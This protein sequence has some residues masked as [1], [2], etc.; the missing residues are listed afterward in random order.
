MR[1][2]IFVLGTRA[3][4]V[5]ISPVLRIAAET[6]L[7]HTVWFT[8]QHHESIDDLID[9]FGLTSNIIQPQD[10]KERSS[11]GKLLLWIPS[12]VFR[13]F[14]FVRSARQLPNGRPLVVVHGDTLSTWLGAI[15]GK[16]A[17][18][19]IVHLESGLSSGKWSD[20]F[21]EELLRR[22][23]FRISSY[24]LC[25]NDEATERMAAYPKCVVINTHENTLL[26]CV[27]YALKNRISGSDL[28]AR[29]VVSIHRFQ[30]LYQKARLDRIVGEIRQLAE[31][32]LVAFILHPPTELRLRKYGLLDG[33]RNTD[34][35]NLLPRMPYTEFLALMG[36]ADM[37][38][39]DG[40]SNQE[41]LSYLGVPTVLYRDRSERPD[42]LGGNIIFRRELATTLTDAV[43]A[44]DIEKLRRE[45]RINDDIHPS[46][47][48]VDAL[49]A[50]ST[51]V[52]DSSSND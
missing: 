35:V 51:A 12:T 33:L 36:D 48:T 46:K 2:C 23:T 32:G 3:Q 16:F 43:V 52:V 47:L 9:D 5:K 4:L 39:S 7:N 8:G 42:G 10:A 19:D 14:R 1:Q 34:N 13:C 49:T 20:P 22:L 26:D 24:A 27:R 15:A 41:E 44:G 18:G 21:P 45:S 25:P 31:L 28:G 17:G 6:G 50:W 11:I 29:F 30:N 40:G 37:V 38:L